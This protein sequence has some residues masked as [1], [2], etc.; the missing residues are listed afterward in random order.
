ML[1][2]VCF[3]VGVLILLCRGI[4]HINFTMHLDYIWIMDPALC[5]AT[6]TTSF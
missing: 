4:Y 6:L 5:A 2:N 1:V 3:I